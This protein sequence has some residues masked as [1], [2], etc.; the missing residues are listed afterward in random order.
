MHVPHPAYADDIVLLSSNNRKVQDLFEAVNHHAAAVGMHTN[1]V[2]SALIPGEQCQDVMFYDE[3][4]EEV[5]KC[6][7]LSSMFITNGRGSEEARS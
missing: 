5:D 7:Y 6:G 3:P 2:T 4:M 1:V